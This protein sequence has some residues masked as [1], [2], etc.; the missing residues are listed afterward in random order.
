MNINTAIYIIC[1]TIIVALGMTTSYLLDQLDESRAT[2]VKLETSID[3]Q[4]AKIKEYELSL[5]DTT[6]TI[7]KDNIII[8]YKNIEVPVKDAT[9]EVKLEAINEIISTYFYRD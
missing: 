2:I 5:K 3:I 8:K 6:D 4:N 9:C 1:G 7:A